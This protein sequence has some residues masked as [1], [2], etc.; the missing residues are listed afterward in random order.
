MEKFGQNHILLVTFTSPWFFSFNG[1]WG[2]DLGIFIPVAVEDLFGC[3]QYSAFRGHRAISQLLRADPI[4]PKNGP[5][6][7]FH[8][9][10]GSANCEKLET[11]AEGC[12]AE[13]CW[14]PLVL[15]F[16]LFFGEPCLSTYYDIL[17]VYLRYA[18]FSTAVNRLASFCIF[19][20]NFLI[21]CDGVPHQKSKQVPF[22]KFD[23]LTGKPKKTTCFFYHQIVRGFLQTFPLGGKH[24]LIPKVGLF[25]PLSSHIINMYMYIY[26]YIIWSSST[27]STKKDRNSFFQYFRLDTLF[28]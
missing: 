8:N 23:G 9:K 10:C 14:M 6:R 21:I 1:T 3:L 20:S 27:V 13:I 25:S 24:H 22:T 4:W 28:Q 18:G 11:N 12:L 7:S 2:V 5:T 15:P 19:I 26:I 17:Y 16:D